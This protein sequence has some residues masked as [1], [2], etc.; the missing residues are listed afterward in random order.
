[1]I[2]PNPFSGEIHLFWQNNNGKVQEIAVYDMMGRK[3]FATTC[4]DCDG[5]NEIIL[6]PALPAGVYVMRVGAYSTKI[7]KM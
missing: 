3:V 5:S 7:V 6:H 1:M 4:A 2:Y